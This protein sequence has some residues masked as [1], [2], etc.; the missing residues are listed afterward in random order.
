MPHIDST[1]DGA[2]AAQTLRGLFFSGH[3]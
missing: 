2:E 3:K 1:W